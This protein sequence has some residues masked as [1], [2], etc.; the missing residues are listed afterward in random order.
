MTAPRSIPAHLPHLAARFDIS[1]EELADLAERSAAKVRRLADWWASAGT[2]PAQV[3]RMLRR[4][5]KARNVCM[6]GAK[7]VSACIN[8]MADPGWWRRALR[9][10]FRAVELH[11][12]QSGAV[13]R[14]ASPYVS[15]AGLRRHEL[16]A[17]R[18]ADQMAALEAVNQSTG[19]TVPMTDL[20]E[21]SLANP[22]NR[23]AA[24]MVRIRG[25]EAQANAKGHRALFITLT[26]PSRMHPRH[27]SGAPNE[28]YNGTFPGR[29]HAYLN[30]VWGRAMR[31]AAHLGLSAY[32]MRVVEPHHDACPHWHALVFTPA[33][34]AEDF[35]A[36]L[37]AY[38]LADSPDEPGAQAHRFKVE[39]ID[40]SKGSATGYVAKYVS[41]A[42][43]GE[44]VDADHEA[45]QDGKTS[46]RRQIAWARTWG[47]RQFQFF[48]VPSITPTRELFRA[49]AH[50]LPGQSLAQLHKACK[51]NDYAGCLAAMEGQGLK[52]SVSYCHRDSTRY[53]GETTK[54]V[55]GLTVAGGDLPGLLTIITHVE[56]WTVQPRPPV[57]VAAL[58]A[59][60]PGISG[61]AGPEAVSPWTRINN[62]ASVDSEGFFSA[63]QETG[64]S[65]AG[66]AAAKVRTRRENSTTTREGA[67]RRAPLPD[68]EQGH[69]EPASRARYRA[70]QQA[71]EHRPA[72]PVQVAKGGHHA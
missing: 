43:D 69:R 41:K 8:R 54:A 5:A 72:P 23:R 20:I 37:R 3:L 35:S 51:A 47:I 1:S 60:V 22:A 36:N 68:A 61:A 33:D 15:S 29:A 11:A 44:G 24:M 66:A 48:G 7:G 56:R 65:P 64:N 9:K 25:I 63:Q 13:H 16:Q 55:Q 38:A 42:I 14:Q 45:D 52:L 21:A 57:A 6:P 53:R 58:A 10:R 67:P 12:I 17:R 2:E 34:Q 62:S 30:R 59:A 31:R 27:H 70:A 40:P 32:G 39:T 71:Q 50:E 46:A 18:L 49:P 28:A 26:C 4:M 19:E